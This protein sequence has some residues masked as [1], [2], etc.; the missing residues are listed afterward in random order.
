MKRL[1]ALPLFATLAGC[2]VIPLPTQPLPDLQFTTPLALGPSEGRLFSEAPLFDAPVPRT[3]RNVTVTGTA[4]LSAPV[5][6]ETRVNVLITR[7]LPGFPGCVPY[8]GYRLCQSGGEVIGTLV[9]AAGSNAAQLRLRSPVLDTLA[10]SGEGYVGLQLAAG[11]VPAGTTLRLNNL[12][13][14]AFL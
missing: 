11:T 14:G 5:A 13:A 4:T 2:G 7:T 1:L 9:F 6:Q 12:R 3:V 10:H 8:S